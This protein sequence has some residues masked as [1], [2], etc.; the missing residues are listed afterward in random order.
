MSALSIKTKTSIC[1]VVIRMINAWRSVIP[2][3]IVGIPFLLFES[4]SLG[5]NICFALLFAII[6]VIEFTCFPKFVGDVYYLR[7]YP[8]VKNILNKVRK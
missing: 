2:I 8:I 3:I 5:D 4:A 1:G 6:V 7:V